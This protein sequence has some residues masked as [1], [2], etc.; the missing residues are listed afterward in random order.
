MEILRL[1]EALKEKGV[2][3][4]ELAEKVDVTENAISLIANGKRQPRF[5]LLMDI[6]NVLDVDL[7]ELFKTTKETSSETIYALRDGQYEPIG[8]LY[9]EK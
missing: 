6:A 7:K 9:S 8:K 3:G 1:K 2:T 5:E 4:K